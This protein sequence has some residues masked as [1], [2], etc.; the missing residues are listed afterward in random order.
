MKIL[1]SIFILFLLSSCSWLTPKY[2]SGL[3]GKDLPNI[4]LLS[5][6]SITNINIKSISYGQ[7]FV[8]FLYHS[9]CP[10]CN[11]QTVD[12][13]KH[14]SF[15]KTVQIY[16]I[17]TDSFTSMKQYST[18]FHLDNYPN[19]IMAHDYDA[20]FLDYFKAPGEPYLAFYDKRQK[21]KHVL[22]GKSDFQVI[23]DILN[24]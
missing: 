20:Q 19:I 17:T 7:P 5:K 11:A 22:L 14:I 2:T 12:I 3:E 18:H 13:L 23:Q 10:Y 1:T 8:L 4:K 15:L 21:L 16:F 9:S 6:D 24:N